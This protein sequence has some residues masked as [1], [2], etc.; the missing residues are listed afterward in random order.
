MS[1]SF[2]ALDPYSTLGISTFQRLSWKRLIQERKC[3]TLRCNLLHEEFL[4]L[5]SKVCRIFR[6]SYLLGFE[7]QMWTDRSRQFWHWLR[8]IRWSCLS[9]HCQA[10]GLCERCFS[11]A[12]SQPLKA[13]VPWLPYSVFHRKITSSLSAEEV[14]LETDTQEQCTQVGCLQRALASVGL[15]HTSRVPNALWSLR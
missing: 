4:V 5:H 13:I 9:R 6:T 2:W 12:Y 8:Q 15:H 1:C 11:S 3:H 7:A 14:Y 10:L